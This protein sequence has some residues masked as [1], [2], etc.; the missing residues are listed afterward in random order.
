M[1]RAVFG[2]ILGVESRSAK[3]WHE[4]RDVGSTKIE[5]NKRQR[6]DVS[7]L[8]RLNVATSQR[9]DVSMSRRLN[10]ATSQ[11]RDV[12]TSRRQRDFCLSII[13]SKKGLEFGGIKE[14][15]NKGT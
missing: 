2:S 3:S 15:T 13:K 4:R 6:H 5:V 12:A 11:R 14:R 9:C 1:E 10:V 7:T 8:R